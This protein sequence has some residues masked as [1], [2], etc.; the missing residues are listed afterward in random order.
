[1][2]NYEQG[3]WKCTSEHNIVKFIPAKLEKL[4]FREKDMSKLLE[5]LLVD[6]ERIVLV[7]G[8]HGMGKSGFVRNT[9]HYVADRKI[10]TGGIL[11]I[12]LVN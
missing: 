3:K 8:L 9:L 11:F 4:K 1:M 7:L 5:I 2:P 6:N 12:D 10:F